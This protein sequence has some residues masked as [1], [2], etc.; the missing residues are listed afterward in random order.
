MG[1]AWAAYSEQKLSQS[2]GEL[3]SFSHIHFAVD[4]TSQFKWDV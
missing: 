3:S 1:P 4:S 2:S